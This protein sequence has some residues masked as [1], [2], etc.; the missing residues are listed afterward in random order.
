MRI[1]LVSDLH[2]ENDPGFTLQPVA[3]ADVLILAGDVGSYQKGS[4]L[5]EPGFGLERFSPLKPGS[6]WRT[7]IY[8]PGN[9]EYDA[10]EFMEAH[11]LLKATCERLGIV[12]LEKEVLVMGKVRFVGTTLWTDFDAFAREAAPGSA[13]EGELR[14][15]AYRA[16]NHYLSKNTCLRQGEPMLAE[17]LRELGLECQAWLREA[18]SQP[19]DGITVA[20]THFAPSL[21]S[22]DPR[23]GLSPGTAGFC[24]ALDELFPLAQ[25]WLHGHLHCRIDYV[26]QGNAGHRCRVIANPLG[27]AGKGERDAYRPELLIE[28]PNGD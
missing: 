3:G 20:V 28:L 16:A 14:A 25:Y 4:R 8:L 23:Y 10:L 11:A 5:V 26:V 18:L 24:N 9:H 15:K 12:W 6:P 19:F 7:V 2:L 22:A 27:Y 17:D 13:R 1:Q 21:R